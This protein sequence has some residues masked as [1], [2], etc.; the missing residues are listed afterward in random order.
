MELNFFFGVG[1]KNK[2]NSSSWILKDFVYNSEDRIWG[3]FYNLFSDDKV[4]VKELIV[5]PNKGISYQRHN[6]RSEFWFIS[7]GNCLIK[8][9]DDN[10]ENYVKT[11]LK[12]EDI[13]TS[14]RFLASTN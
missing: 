5:H 12:E 10:P 7:K 6:H 1:E 4:K 11:K 13:F 3:K 2:K 9:S 8:H 14:K